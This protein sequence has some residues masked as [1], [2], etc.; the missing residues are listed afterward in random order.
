MRSHSRALGRWIIR[1]GLPCF[2]GLSLAACAPV[3]PVSYSLEDSEIFIAPRPHSLIVAVAVLEDRRSTEE[4]DWGSRFKLPPDLAGAVTARIIQH[5]R[6]SSVFSRVQTVSGPVD[7]TDPV[8]VHE[9]IT[10]S[11]DAVLVGEL[12][13]YYGKTHPDRRV[14]GHVRFGGLK[15][16]SVH[17]GELL[18]KGDADKLLQRQE[19]NPGRDDFYAVE[20]LR[21]AINQVAIQLSGQAFSR[22]QVYPIELPAIRR[23]QVGVLLPEDLR[24]PEEK[25]TEVRRLKGNLNY[26]LYSDTSQ[27][28]DKSFFCG[29]LGICSTPKWAAAP[30]IDA[31]AEQWVQKLKT[32]DIFGNVLNLAT[33]G[34]TSEE[35]RQWS[36]EGIDAVLISRLAHSSGSVAP[37]FETRSFPIWSGGMGFERR[38]KATALTRIEDVQLI[39]TRT[40]NVLWKGEAEYGIDRTIQRWESPMIILKESLSGTLDRLVKRLSQFA[41][42]PD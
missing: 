42:A 27:S 18:W 36:E 21:G 26:S 37:P 15:L 5:L 31:V 25:D 28:V 1:T 30:V 20:A 8:R 13:H 9:L 33:R 39:E 32:A 40:G 6:V 12:I 2:L 38:F 34:I 11:T 10:Q 14:E 3:R 41:Q 7:L 22:Q 35:L 19:R 17:T 4:K 24:P 23:W 29:V 16:Y